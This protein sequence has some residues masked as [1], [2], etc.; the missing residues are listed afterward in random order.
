VTTAAVQAAEIDHLVVA[1]ASLEQGAAWCEATLGVVPAPGGKHANFGTHNRLLKIEGP[2]FPQAYLEIIALDPQGPP[3]TRPRWF[4]LDGA[5]MQADLHERG[6]RLVHAVVRTRSLDA[7]LAA[8]VAAGMPVGEAIAASRQ[9]AAGLLQWRIVV[10]KDGAL[11]CGGALPTLIE[12]TG[13]HP[14]LSMADS[15]VRLN[16][17]SL[18][19]V[20]PAAAAALGLPG[21]RFV[22]QSAPALRATFDTPRAAVTLESK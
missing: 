10:R 4:G 8:L 9:G 12:W 19:G 16:A 13:Q 18:G 11:L 2:G 15:G 1:A 7:Q 6:P 21:V 17:L 22:A 5:A 14:T 20:P 3:P